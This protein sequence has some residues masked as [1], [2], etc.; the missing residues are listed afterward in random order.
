[1]KR[2]AL[3]SFGLAAVMAFWLLLNG[4]DEANDREASPSPPAS[5]S[6]TTVV[7]VASAQAV[8]PL[9]AAASLPSV[10]SKAAIVGENFQADELPLLLAEYE[11]SVAFPPGSQPITA[12]DVEQYLP[13]RSSEVSQPFPL[14]DTPQP[15]LIS[16]QMDK[17]L[18][19]EGEPVMA[20][21][22]VAQIPKGR[23]V[24]VTF[25][26]RDLLDHTLMDIRP[27]ADGN[28]VF[29]A[30]IDL[31]EAESHVNSAELLLQAIVQA[32][33]EKM[34]VAAPFRYEDSVAMLE[35]ILPS[36]M[37]AA[38]LAMPLV[39]TVTTAG[40]YFVSAN[41]YSQASGEPLVHLETEGP[42]GNG[43][44][45]LTF[46]AHGSALQARGDAGPYWLQDFHIERAAGP[47]EQRDRPGRSSA[48]R[49]A[50]EGFA[51]DSYPDSQY[52]DPL[53][54]ERKA[55]LEKLGAM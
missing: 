23:S 43:L 12:E 31:R 7:P 22:S 45:R 40:Y 8:L 6:V 17:Y 32:G 47:G 37:E 5:A 3:A 41:L 53:I 25:R 20:V 18:Y 13:N 2:I 36:Y 27:A 11:E 1:M 52:E 26:V 39:F 30:V 48:P 29:S 50:V 33:S 28:G 15:V 4:K 46:L 19:F 49:F 42:L 10:S 21:A 24:S 54:E 34:L 38:S 44:N 16:L 55:F 35:E 9:S 14:A 51:L